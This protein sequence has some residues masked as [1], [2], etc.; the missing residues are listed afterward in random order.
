VRLARQDTGSGVIDRPAV[1]RCATPPAAVLLSMVLVLLPGWAAL[2]AALSLVLAPAL[3]GTDPDRPLVGHA[4]TKF[5]AP[6][7][8]NGMIEAALG[9][10]GLA[11]I[12]QALAK[13]GAGIQFPAPITRDGEGWR[14][15]VDLP[16]GVTALE[17]AERREK[18]AS[19]L[20]R[21]SGAVWPERD[22]DPGQHDGRL[23]LWVGDRPMSQ[24]Q[25][26]PW[27]LAKTGA[28]DLFKP[29]PYGFDQRGR[30][31]T[32]SLMYSNLLVGAIPS[33]GKSFAVRVVALAAALDPIVELHCHELKGTGDMQSV[34]GRC[35]RYTSGPPAEDTLTSVMRSL[36]EVHGY[37][38]GRARRI[39][40]LPK[41]LCPE[42]K[43]TP[44][45]SG[46]R[47]LGLWPSC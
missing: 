13:N 12:N 45:L 32:L 41:D 7:L 15:D 31:V 35:H 14:A 5:E 16:L 18:L 8:T 19:G 30:L 23:I 29:I 47:D 3:V 20:R 40:R 10:I 24:A 37:L 43:V 46:R 28:A 6:K 36:R 22:P 33:Q 44:L 1:C 4:V 27:P 25:Q 38:D 11:G 21:P 9:S 17:V 34:E 2:A 42:S 39:G 26:P